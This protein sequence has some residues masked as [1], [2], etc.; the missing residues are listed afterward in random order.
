MA[1]NRTTHQWSLVMYEL[2]LAHLTTVE[3]ERD[4]EA[5]LRQRRILKASDVA[6]RP[7]GAPTADTITL[8]AS[9]GLP[10]TGRVR[11]VGR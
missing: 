2:T 3:H 6:R 9:R 8:S 11:T 10:A 1:N 4:L 5:D 7:L